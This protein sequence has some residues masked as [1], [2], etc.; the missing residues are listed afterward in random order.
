MGRWC[1]GAEGGGGD[2]SISSLMIREGRVVHLFVWGGL[3]QAGDEADR[4]LRYSH[5]P[6]SA[7]CWGV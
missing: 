5:M 2:G 6:R 7:G 3:W 4:P 1:G